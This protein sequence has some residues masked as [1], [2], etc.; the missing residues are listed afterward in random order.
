MSSIAFQLLGYPRIERDGTRIELP[1]R[2]A[3]A[4]AI[5]LAVTGRPHSRD[6]LIAQAWPE[7][8]ATR[9][10]ADLRRHLHVIGRAL[11]TDWLITERDQVAAVVT[12]TWSDTVEFRRLVAEAG[13]HPHGRESFCPS[14]LPLLE[15]ALALYQDDFLSGFSLAD[16]P[17]F[18]DW[19]FMESE[20]LRGLLGKA[21]A[22]LAQG[23]VRAGDIERAIRYTER[24]LALDPLDERVQRCL[25]RLLAWNGRP[26]VA[27]RQFEDCAQL[28]R[29]ELG[30]APDPATEELRVAISARRLPPPPLDPDLRRAL[31]RQGT[32][33]GTAHASHFEGIRHVTA[34]AVHLLPSSSAHASDLPASAVDHSV[35]RTLSGADSWQ[36]IVRATVASLGGHV[37]AAGDS[38]ILA[39]FGAQGVHEDDAERATRAAL[40]IQSDLVARGLHASMATTTGSAYVQVKYAVGR[41]ATS[42]DQLAVTVAGTSITF[43]RQ[44]AM[45][46]DEPDIVLDRSTM[47]LVRGMVACHERTLSLHHPT[48][49]VT[50]YALQRLRRHPVK[51]RGMSGLHAPLTG[52]R[53]E[54][55]QLRAALTRTMSGDGQIAVV[56][57]FAG[58]GKSRLVAELKEWANRRYVIREEVTGGEMVGDKVTDDGIRSILWLEGR[59]MD[60]AGDTGYGL[61]ADLLRDLWS[62]RPELSVARQAIAT[63]DLL[64]TRG[65]LDAHSVDEIAP[66]LGRIMSV[67]YNNHWDTRLQHVDPQQIRQRTQS[68]VNQFLLALAQLQPLV[69]VL[70]DLHWSDNLSLE[71]IP[72]LLP[73][74]ADVPLLVIC[75]YRAEG[76]MADERIATLARRHVSDRFT[77]LHLRELTQVESRNLIA[78]LL[79]TDAL[80]SDMRSA[81]LQ[82]AQGNPLFLE[83]IVRSLIETQRLHRVGEYWQ[84]RGPG[85]RIAVPDTLQRIVIS[86]VEQLPARLRVLLQQA[87]VLGRLFTTPVLEAMAD[88]TADLDAD[89][90]QLTRQSFVYLERALPTPEYSFHHVLVRD[91][92]YLDLPENQ[93][94]AYHRRAA[95]AMEDLYAGDVT[96]HV[97]MLAYHYGLS[98]TPVLALPYLLQSGEKARRAYLNDAAVEAFQRVLSLLDAQPLTTI[99]QY[100]RLAAL[101]GL[102]Q[103]YAATSRFEEAERMLYAA[104]SLGNELRAP[105][106]EQVRRYYWLVDEI[107]NWQPRPAEGLRLIQEVLALLGDELAPT[108]TAIL[109]GLQAICAFLVGDIA[110]WDA[111]HR[112]IIPMLDDVEICEELRNAYEG[113]QFAALLDR[114]PARALALGNQAVEAPEQINDL[115]WKAEALGEIAHT[116]M[117]AGGAP[118]EFLPYLDEG[119]A[120]F[121]QIDERKRANWLAFEHLAHL[122]LHGDDVD[123]DALNAVLVDAYIYNAEH[124]GD[125]MAWRGVV[126]LAAGDHAGARADVETMLARNA[127]AGIQTVDA[128]VF[129]GYLDLAVHDHAAARVHFTEALER[130][131]DPDIVL[132]LRKY[133]FRYRSY[134]ASAL[135]GLE[136]ALADRALFHAYCADWRARHARTSAQ[137]F[138]THWYLTAAEVAP[139]AWQ[140]VMQTEF[141]GALASAWTWHDPAGGAAWRQ[142]HGLVIEAPN[143]RDLWFWFITAPRLLQAA[144]G[145]LAIQTLCAPA[146]PDRPGIGGLLLWL[147]KETYVRLDHGLH[148]PG[149]ISL[150]GSLGKR[151]V[152]IGRGLLTGSPVHLRL[153][154]I[155]TKVRGLCSVDGAVWFC[156]GALDL[157]TSAQVQVG[158]FVANNL[159]RFVYP[160]LHPH[161][162]AMRFR[163]FRL[164]RPVLDEPGF[165]D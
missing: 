82:R 13:D 153:E 85:N 79:Q 6:A 111:V 141:D 52:R 16:S 139:Q 74:L 11:G 165:R 120:L 88:N 56:A 49:T 155:G 134:F 116:H 33:P 64:R 37:V 2:R 27:L 131:D 9:G 160:G 126:K 7:I 107:I 113:V 112:M 66:L 8:D 65:Y 162:T 84:A 163:T 129:L 143:T 119:L 90:A 39:A 152:M 25:M 106:K 140:P 72:A 147:D 125:I 70:E 86:R 45:Q 3:L 93:R 62:R 67:Q 61:V 103:V 40:T 159:D 109:Y 51:V 53:A 148:G 137:A 4:L 130:M 157:P 98:D 105:V 18:D 69:L 31:S 5:Y 47:N 127:T 80:S 41:E 30:V 43:A 95:E 100:Q 123:L 128:L 161:G 110:Q 42:D 32:Q 135:A 24:R 54:L 132:P 12:H 142:E 99:G 146:A 50:V 29:H 102:G 158:L 154:R 17:A 108:E 122:L 150:A 68:A 1:R 59:G 15:R 151:D 20:E 104:V 73:E 89:L 87:A 115:R 83:E 92:L 133:D 78:A 58:V 48:R 144:H 46:R 117:V 34:L 36:T 44:T 136:R 38:D 57:G 156:V 91:A 55:D 35:E 23:Y 145:D 96:P 121:E 118:A 22:Q 21:L 26:A 124:V 138:F 114:D 77:E 71:L 149:E 14:C 75:L 10:R 60:F 164:E 19:S 97:E 94:A 63:F 28:L 81:I 76:V 101:T